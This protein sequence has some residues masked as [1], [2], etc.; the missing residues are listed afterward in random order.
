MSWD[1]CRFIEL[2]YFPC[3]RDI[4]LHHCSNECY[5]FKINIYTSQAF[6]KVVI[7]WNRILERWNT[8][9]WRLLKTV[10]K[11]ELTVE[12]LANSWTISYFWTKRW[13]IRIRSERLS[14]GRLE[15]RIW[16]LKWYNYP[17]NDYENVGTIMD[18][19]SAHCLYFG[20]RF[21]IRTPIWVNQSLK[22]PGNRGLQ[23]LCC[24]F[25]QIMQ[26]WDRYELWKAD[27]SYGNIYKPRFVS[28]P[29]YRNKY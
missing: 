9:V 25:F 21:F 5:N 26:L 6:R 4:W 23:F 15:I 3:L 14:S 27:V 20:H 29:L 16:V 13:T 10:L 7:C 28:L 17:L 22:N 18:S 19:S 2:R 8:S 12:R 24:N 11:N 1:I